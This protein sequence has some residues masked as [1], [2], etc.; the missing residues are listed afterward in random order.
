[1]NYLPGLPVQDP[2]PGAARRGSSQDAGLTGGA[3][4]AFWKKMGSLLGNVD[5]RMA[6]ETPGVRRLLEGEMR[7][8]NAKIDGLSEIVNAN[9]RNLDDFILEVGKRFEGTYQESLA[10]S[11]PGLQGGKRMIWPTCK[12]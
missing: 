3:D 12:L 11:A 1:M 8:A 10:N 4:E 6:E 5:S 2:F 7:K 9:E